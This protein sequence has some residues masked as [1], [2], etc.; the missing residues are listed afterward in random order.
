M[1][2]KAQQ[3]YVLTLLIA[4][5]GVQALRLFRSANIPRLAPSRDLRLRLGSHFPRR[6]FSEQQPVSS[7]NDV[8]DSSVNNSAPGDD[9]GAS[10]TS[11]KESDIAG[12]L[13]AKEQEIVDITVTAGHCF[14]QDRVH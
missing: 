7:V 1:Q 2:T 11:N 14:T 6:H 12:R 10:K 13:Q 3:Y 9:L 8:G 5:N 4:M